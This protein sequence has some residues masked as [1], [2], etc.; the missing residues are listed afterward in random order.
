M[1]SVFKVNEEWWI[2]SNGWLIILK[3]TKNCSKDPHLFKTRLLVSG[4]VCLFYFIVDTYKVMNRSTTTRI[5]ILS[6]CLSGF[7]F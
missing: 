3:S 1:D 4:Y 7:S 2:R 5:D 6:T